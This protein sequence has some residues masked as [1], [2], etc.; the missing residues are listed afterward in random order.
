MYKLVEN[1]LQI[2]NHWITWKKKQNNEN[3]K[4]TNNIISL[5]I[6]F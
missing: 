5:K 4:I 1:W 3:E 2:D 6:M